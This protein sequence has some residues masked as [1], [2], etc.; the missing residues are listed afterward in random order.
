MKKILLATRNT[1]KVN[2]IRA[3]MQHAPFEFV[4][5]DQYNFP[6]AEEAGKTF[7][8]NALIKARQASAFTH[9]P[10][11]ADDSGL[12]VNALNGAPGIY[13]ARY[14]GENAPNEKC[15]Q[16]LLAEL[17]NVPEE[18]RDARFCCAAVF[19]RHPDDPLP[20]IA[21]GFLEGQILFEPKGENGFGYD[22]LFYLPNKKCS[23]AE[24]PPEI[25]N[26]L[27][28]RA[29]A[30]RQLMNFLHAMNIQ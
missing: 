9:L 4:M 27:S 17:K 24:L 2:E 11:I 14:A 28:H 13:S 12:C 25:K 10:V 8:E 5:L 21:Q 7:I 30:F 23:V 19:L 1:H 16:K 20:I 6:E 3:I 22:P 29:K 26:Q 18:K 15:L